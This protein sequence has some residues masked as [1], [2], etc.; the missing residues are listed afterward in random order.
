MAKLCPTKTRP[1]I[2]SA[3]EAKLENCKLLIFFN[4]NYQDFAKFILC[5]IFR[6]TQ[7]RDTA[8]FAV[9]GCVSYK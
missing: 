9:L 7:K 8:F 2:C 1:G 6:V 3:V 4:G 5:T